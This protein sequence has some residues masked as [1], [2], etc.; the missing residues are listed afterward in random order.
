MSDNGNF[1]LTDP[2]GSAPTK[3]PFSQSVSRGFSQPA[4]PMS[5][6]AANAT[7]ATTTSAARAIRSFF[8]GNGFFAGS[9]AAP[10]SWNVPQYGQAF[11]SS[12]ICLP[13]EPQNFMFILLSL[14]GM[15]PIYP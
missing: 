5:F 1:K 12:G 13:Q 8:T 9:T 14:V 3:G 10:N 6:T 7:A 2:F 15:D 4:P 11:A